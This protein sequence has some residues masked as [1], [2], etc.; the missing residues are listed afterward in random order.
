MRTR[1]FL[2]L[3]IV[4]WAIYI[5]VLLTTMPK[6]ESITYHELTVNVD[7]SLPGDDTPATE[8]CYITK[9]EIQEDRENYYIEQAL[10]ER[11]NV[12]EDCTVT[13]YDCCVK[14]CGKDNGITA[15]GVKATPGVTVGVDPNIIPLGSDVLVDYGNGEIHYYRADDTGV[16]GNHIDLC[17]SSH[18]EA[19]QLGICKATVYWVEG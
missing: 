3:S 16:K 2:V 10:L 1:L 15:S 18:E 17:V 11:A 12:I 4:L 5:A 14:C 19:L 9:E 13:H 7:G 8:K 6:P